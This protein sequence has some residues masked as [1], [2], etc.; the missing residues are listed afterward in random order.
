MSKRVR[1]GVGWIRLIKMNRGSYDP[2]LSFHYGLDDG[3]DGL[4]LLIGYTT[5]F[6][7]R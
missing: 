2:L 3:S 5:H 4:N 7:D 1:D 6:M